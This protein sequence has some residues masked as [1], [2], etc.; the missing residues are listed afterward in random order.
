MSDADVAQF[1]RLVAVGLI[2]VLLAI[3]LHEAAHGF[4]AARLGDPTAERLGRVT[5]NPFKHVDALGTVIVP[6]LLL[7]TTG[8]PFG[9]AKPVPVNLRN[10]RDP[11]RGMVVVAAAGPGANLLMAVGW[12]LLLVLGEGLGGAL[13]GAGA[14]V[15]AMSQF[16]I[17]FNVLLAV[18]NLLPLP[19][20]DGGR[21]LRGLLPEPLGRLLDRVEPWGLILVFALL[22]FGV[23]NRVLFPVI[24]RVTGLLFSLAGTLIR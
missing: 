4:A 20:L 14:F 17:Q 1:L 15:V 9:W 8:T 19:P 23:L 22:Y 12:M 21:V 24:Q 11:K 10:L 18:F 2:P 6:L 16:G 13:G 5:A 3:A 7:A